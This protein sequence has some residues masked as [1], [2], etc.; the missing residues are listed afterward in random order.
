MKE[1]DMPNLI[2][3]GKYVFHIDG[4]VKYQYACHTKAAI[5]CAKNKTCC[6]QIFLVDTT[7]TK[8]DRITSIFDTITEF[9]SNLKNN[10]DYENP[11]EHDR[12]NQ[13]FIDKK[14]DDYCVFSYFDKEES[15]KCGIHSAALKLDKDPF[16][17]KPLTC[18]LWPLTI[19]NTKYK[20]EIS[21]DTETKTSCLK[22]KK[23]SDTTI[24]LHFLEII[25]SLLGKRML[26]FHEAFSTLLEDNYLQTT[27]ASTA[28]LSGTNM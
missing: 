10:G 14:D 17:Y 2:T 20:V 12:A 8:I 13:F 3:I 24:D 4:L 1:T 11:F 26:L 19:C 5:T 28:R 22:K 15:L 9:C 27:I 16:Y 6:C 7:K 25:R 18:C 21:L 23:K